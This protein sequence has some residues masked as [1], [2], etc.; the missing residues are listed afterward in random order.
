MEGEQER[1]FPSHTGDAELARKSTPVPVERRK[2]EKK[3]KRQCEA[4]RSDDAGRMDGRKTKKKK[5]GE[6]CVRKQKQS[7]RRFVYLLPR[8]YLD[9]FFII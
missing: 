6:T 2:D 1:G 3:N 5:K 9:A 7:R 4:E 8:S